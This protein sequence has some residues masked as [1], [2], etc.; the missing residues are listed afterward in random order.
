MSYLAKLKKLIFKIRRNRNWR[1]YQFIY[2][3][4]HI[5]IRR[6]DPMLDGD[7]TYFMESP[8]LVREIMGVNFSARDLQDKVVVAAFDRP[9]NC[10][11]KN[12]INYTAVHSILDKFCSMPEYLK[13]SNGRVNKIVLLRSGKGYLSGHQLR[14]NI[15]SSR[16]IDVVDLDGSVDDVRTIY[17]K[18]A[19]ALVI[20]NTAEAGYVSEKFFD[21]VKSGCNILYYGCSKT[22]N[23]LGFSCISVNESNLCAAFLDELIAT[24]DYCEYGATQNYKQ[25]VGLRNRVNRELIL[26]PA[27]FLMRGEF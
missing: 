6:H 26:L 20:E 13:L 10:N 22:V 2:S 19:F 25:L 5:S 11:V 12:W 23:E 24:S 15:N 14:Q 8:E 4:H 18:Y 1:R 7:I 17:E 3:K 27:F 16:F 9:E 21:A